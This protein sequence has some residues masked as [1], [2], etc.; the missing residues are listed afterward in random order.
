MENVGPLEV[1]DLSLPFDESDAPKPVV[2]VGQNGSGKTVLLSHIV[3]AL[4]EFAKNAYQDILVGQVGVRTPYFKTVGGTNQRTGTNFGIA[5]LKFSDGESDYCYLDKSGTLDPNSYEKTNGRFSALASWPTEDNHKV[6]PI[7]EGYSERFFRE[8]S[9]CYFPSARHE[10][11]HWLNPEG[12]ANE[13]IFSFAENYT[14]RLYKPVIVES[15]A[16]ENKQWLLDVILDSR[17]E[18][19][20]VVVRQDPP[21]LGLGIASNQNDLWWL[22]QSRHMVD[23]ILK[24]ILHNNSARLSLGYRTGGNRLFIETDSGTIPS[25]DHLS[26]GQANLFNLFTTIIRYAD[27]GDINKSFKL[28]D[29]EGIVLVD[30]IEAQAHSDLQYEVLPQLL[31]MFP[32]VQFILT[33][34]SPLFLLGMER[35]Y[36]GEGFQVIEMPSGQSITTERFSEFERSWEYYR[37]TAAYEQDLEKALQTGSKPKVFTEGETDPHYIKAALK[38]LERQDL[39]KALDIEWV[40]TQGQQGPLNTGQKGLDHTRNVLEANPDLTNSRVLLLYDCD[41][42]KPAEDTGRISVRSLPK[43]ES[44]EKVRRGI[45]NLLPDTL[46]EPRFYSSKTE[47]GNYGEQTKIEKFDKVSFCR[48]IC[49]ERRQTDDFEHFSLVIELLEEFLSVTAS[50][51]PASQ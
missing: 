3:D 48:W 9:V 35:V 43:N 1:V 19:Q 39:L 17:A 4:I 18:V 50:N 51:T 14:G 31:K 40:G 23:A 34:H 6:A 33:S 47:I 11:P 46:F 2:L 20:P 21:Q 37:R 10:R 44:N 30:E 5:L 22:L 16:Q 7:P 25:L 49:E 27:R 24:Q 12:V 36:G 29:I 32:K 8:S 42:S 45:E 15:A 28:H 38:L 26:S 13:P 41:T